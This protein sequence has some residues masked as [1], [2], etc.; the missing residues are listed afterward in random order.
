MKMQVLLIALALTGSV[1][2][3]AK[4]FVN[5]YISFELPDK[6]TCELEGTEWV[7]GSPY[8]EKATQAIII[9]TAKESG[10]SDTLSAYKAHLQTPKSIPLANG[11]FKSSRVEHLRER[12]I[13]NH[14]WVDGMHLGSEVAHFYTRYLATVKDQLGIVVTFSAHEKYYTQYINDFLNAIKSLKVIAP[15]NLLSGDYSTG[16]GAPI[17]PPQT[18]WFPI[19]VSNRVADLPDS[20]EDPSFGVILGAAFLLGAV[21]IYLILKK[22]RK[23]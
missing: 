22:R 10:P 5:T 9:L 15:K 12:N 18:P 6:W 19:D 16:I 7:C 3:Y 1:K 21:G 14:T 13:N 4:L 2:V 11:T 23:S 20:N 17:N 8:K